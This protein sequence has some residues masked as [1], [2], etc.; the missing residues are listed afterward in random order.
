MEAEDKAVKP[1]RKR[2]R[3]RKS[4]VQASEPVAQDQ[5]AVHPSHDFRVKEQ[6]AHHARK[7]EPVLESYFELR[8]TPKGRKLSKVVKKPGR[9]HRTFI[10]RPEK[11]EAVLR[12]IEQLEGEGRLRKV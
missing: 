10:G 3:P 1:K 6:E 4:E 8:H 9:T 12:Y 2:G 7:K 11:D 5:E